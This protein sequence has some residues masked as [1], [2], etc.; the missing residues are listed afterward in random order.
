MFKRGMAGVTLLNSA[1][2]DVFGESSG[3]VVVF[4]SSTLYLFKATAIPNYSAYS[5]SSF[6]V[7][8]LWLLVLVSKSVTPALPLF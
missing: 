1:E 5:K 8:F 3:S 4:H 6:L 7:E 2:K